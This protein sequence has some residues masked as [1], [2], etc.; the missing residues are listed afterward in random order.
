[1]TLRDYWD[2]LR[3]SWFLIAISAVLGALAA[4]GLSLRIT[5]MYQAESQLF[6][7]VQSTDEISGAS[8]GNMYVQ[9]RMKSY[10]SVVDTPAVLEPVI[11]KLKLDM[12]SR[13][14]SQ[15]R[16]RQERSCST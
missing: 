10:V 5:P 13:R 6:V 15:R 2:I 11:D 4:L 14:R 9:Q 1:M 7:S 12:S 8:T 3:R 16:T